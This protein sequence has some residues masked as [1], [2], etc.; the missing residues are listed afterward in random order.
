VLT[1]PP[2]IVKPFGCDISNHITQDEID[3][4]EKFVEGIGNHLDI[5]FPFTVDI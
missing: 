4:G 1:F 2:L 3:D 5:R